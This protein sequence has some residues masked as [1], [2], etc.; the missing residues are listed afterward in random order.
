MGEGGGGGGSVL[1]THRHTP[2]HTRPTHTYQ[3]QY[4]FHLLTKCA[5]IPQHFK[6]QKPEAGNLFYDPSMHLGQY[7][8]GKSTGR[9]GKFPPSKNRPVPQHLHSLALLTQL[10]GTFLFLIFLYFSCFSSYFCPFCYLGRAF[11]KG[12]VP[13]RLTKVWS[14]RGGM[15]RAHRAWG[16]CTGAEH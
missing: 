1:H 6:Q 11:R 12:Y 9:G 14:E 13:V 16:L 5:D 10:P 8:Q 3:N 15:P 7:K 2:I 4:K